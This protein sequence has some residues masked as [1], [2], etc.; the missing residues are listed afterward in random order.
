MTTRASQLGDTPVDGTFLP[1]YTNSEVP[2]PTVGGC[3]PC[4]WCRGSESEILAA[5]VDTLGATG[6]FAGVDCAA[7]REIARACEIVRVD[8]HRTLFEEGEQ[9]EGLWILAS[10]RLRLYHLDPDGRQFVMRFFKPGEAVQ[11]SPALDGGTHGLSCSALED[12]VLVLIPGAVVQA[13]LRSQ[14]AFARNVVDALCLILRRRNVAATTQAFFDAASRVRCALVQ[15]AYQYGVP[16]E[17]G[18]QR[19]NYR[20]TRQDIADYV[21]VT[22]ETSI[23]V[24]SQM[25]RESVLISESK[26]MEI[27]DFPGFVK[28]TGCATCQFDCR[29]IF[30]HSEPRHPS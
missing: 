20:L 13:T 5:R 27:P 6:L 14:L 7:V 8:A 28:A 11:L 16:S 15:F 30:G 12:S 18:G 4:V 17:K 1:R 10:G 22:V 19:I 25:Q 29:S 2:R 9:C 21:G 26:L 3:P 24:L 23:R